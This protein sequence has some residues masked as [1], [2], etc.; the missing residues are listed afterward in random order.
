MLFR[1][2]RK[3]LRPFALALSLLLPSFV[4]AQNTAAVTVAVRV[5]DPTGNAVPHAQ[6]RVVPAPDA[7]AKLETDSKGQMTLDLKPGGYA[8]FVRVPG[9]KNAVAHLDVVNADMPHS[10]ARAAKPAQTFE[11]KLQVGATG[12]LTVYPVSAKDNLLVSAYPYHDPIRFAF[13]DLKAMQHTT[14][15]FRNAHTNADETYSGVRLADL[16]SKVGA[17]LG[18][19]L[20]GEALTNYIVVTGA[21]GY[22][23]VLALAEVDPSFHPG[24]V[25][26]ADGMNGQPLD[27]HSGPL[28]LVVTEDNRPARSVR[29]LTS[30]EL[31]L[32]P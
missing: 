31:K 7:A 11:I 29:N 1:M 2:R 9:F 23:A 10:E 3:Q 12:S 17:P 15:T 22:Q 18:P 25:L 13:A 5:T 14:V 27:A 30:I 4:A 8:I 20:R 24:E 6:V 21:D 26:V 19:E 16:L 28:K 32:F